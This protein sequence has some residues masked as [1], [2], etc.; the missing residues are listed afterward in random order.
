MIDNVIGYM[1]E[2][3]L[4]TGLFHSVYGLC[5]LITT[6]DKTFPASYN[7]KGEFEKVGNFD[8]ASGLGYFRDGGNV[9]FSD[10]ENQ[11]TSCNKY[12]NVTFPLIFVG[13]VRKT[14]LNCDNA[15]AAHILAQTVSKSLTNTSGIGAYVDVL[16]ASSIVKEYSTD[17][18]EILK[19]EYHNPAL[20]EFNLKYAYISVSFDVELVV[21]KNCIG[22][23]CYA[24]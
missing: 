4:D 24:Y 15:Y 21:D 12:Y 5:E 8:S 19:R 18:S 2:N 20:N 1:R 11:F 6:D 14:K 13:A 9:I 17:G 23:T 7:G 3:V 22:I 10:S 16:Q